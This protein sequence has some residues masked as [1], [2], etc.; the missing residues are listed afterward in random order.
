MKSQTAFF[1]RLWKGFAM[2]VAA[3]I[4]GISGGTIA[5]LL[6]IYDEIIEAINQLRHQF[7]QSFT[8]L[9]PIGLGVVL[10]IVALTIPMGLAFESFPLPTVSLFAGLILGGLPLLAKKATIKKDVFS[11]TTILV[12]AFIAISLGV[13]SVVG[14]LDAT[15]ILTEETI[16]PKFSLI[17]IGALGV[18]AFIVPGISGSMLLL[19]LG[20]YQPILGSLERILEAL[21]SPFQARND[22]LNF[23]FLGLGLLVG[24]VLISALMGYLLKHHP[25]AVYL[26]VFG[27][28][29]GSLFSVFFNFEIIPAYDSLNGFQGVLSGIT[30]MGGMMLSYRFNTHYA[31]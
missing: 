30:L 8:I 27:F 7:K 23:V 5:F 3:I 13:F 26:A 31:S 29:A 21:P 25:R 9:L 15:A 17:L 16:L 6:G 12:P 22:L 10:A 11:I 28:V 24:F 18:S 19:S 14:E 2:G 20:F 1:S 4:P